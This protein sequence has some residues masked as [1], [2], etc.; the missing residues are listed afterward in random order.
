MFGGGNALIH[1]GV[2]V[3]NVMLQNV[4]K[5]AVVAVV[6]YLIYLL[7]GM[8]VSGLFLQIFFVLLILVYIGF[9]LNLFGINF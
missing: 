9:L 8:I 6:L 1:K 5:A 4:L 2:S 3:N 7:V